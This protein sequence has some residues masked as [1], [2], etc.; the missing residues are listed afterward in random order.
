MGDEMEMVKKKKRTLSKLYEPE[1]TKF[2]ILQHF[3][4]IQMNMFD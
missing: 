3:K 1:A 4:N 2:L